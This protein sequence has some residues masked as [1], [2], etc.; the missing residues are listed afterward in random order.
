MSRVDVG[1]LP[2]VSYVPAFALSYG[3][4]RIARSGSLATTVL[5]SFPTCINLSDHI[6]SR[7]F[8]IDPGVWVGLTRALQWTANR[9]FL[10]AMFAAGD[11]FLLASDPAL[12]RPG[13]WLFHE[14]H[15]LRSRG[16]S[17]PTAPSRPTSFWAD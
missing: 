17:V 15:H 1:D 13:S 4:P 2:F 11:R 12:A 8:D 14:L 3:E 9:Y 5:G 16:A 10:D 7:R 6:G